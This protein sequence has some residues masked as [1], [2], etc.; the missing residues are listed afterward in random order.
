LELFDVAGGRNMARRRWTGKK[1]IRYH[2]AI[3]YT[4]YSCVNVET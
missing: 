3:K 4:C 1:A 2:W